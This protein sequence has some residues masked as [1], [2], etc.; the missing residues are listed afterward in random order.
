MSDI[1]ETKV[2]QTASDVFGVP[3][4]ELKLTSAPATVEGW[5]SV[6]HLNLVLALEEAVGVSIDPEE[7]EQMQ[8]LGDIVQLLRAKLPS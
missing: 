7:I 6:Q 8:T 3:V 4:A 1:I 5:D 2:F